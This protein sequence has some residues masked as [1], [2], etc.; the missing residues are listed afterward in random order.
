MF[1]YWDG[2]EIDGSDTDFDIVLPEQ[3][4][5]GALVKCFLAMPLFCGAARFG[6]KEIARWSA[7][8]I[9]EED[10]IGRA[11]FE[12][13]LA[14]GDFVSLGVVVDCLHPERLGDDLRAQVFALSK[15][16]TDRGVNP[17]TVPIG[18]QAFMSVDLSISK[19]RQDWEAAHFAAEAEQGVYQ[20]NFS[21]EELP[22]KGDWV[23]TLGIPVSSTYE[24]A[25][26]IIQYLQS[27]FPGIGIWGGEECSC[28]ATYGT[29]LY[30]YEKV[31]LP[32]KYSVKNTLKR[33]T[34]HGIVHSIIS[35]YKNRWTTQR[36]AQ[37]FFL[38]GSR[39]HWAGAPVTD[40][41]FDEYVALA[42][43]VLADEPRLFE[44][45]QETAVDIQLP[46][47]EYFETDPAIV[48]AL[49]EVL[50]A[51]YPAE[52]RAKMYRANWIYTGYLAFT[53]VD[54]KAVCELR[55]HSTMRNY[56]H[57]LLALMDAG[58]IDYIKAETY[59]QRSEVTWK[60]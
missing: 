48:A 13:R 49:S 28:G 32:V 37:G 16:G 35:Y 36:A 22:K 3:V 33:L 29:S 2:Y 57:T 56:L 54:G 55:V 59:Q 26:Y 30:G 51:A 50:D 43:M 17:C 42:E 34:E 6:A 18:R 1:L 40:L 10:K 60:F 21:L 8:H 15:P 39:Q 7:G 38:T 24:Y 11:D 31:Q 5:V 46:P 12:E 53:T 14:S 44:Q 27:H 41:P 45:V 25:M 4:Q 19:V 47:P 23:L 20:Y 58:R 9:A 52:E